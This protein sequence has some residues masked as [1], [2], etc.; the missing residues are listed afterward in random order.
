[1]TDAPVTEQERSVRLVEGELTPPSANQGL[2][3]VFRRRYL[4]RL[5]VRR[6]LRARYEASFLG[7]LWSYINPLSQFFIYWFVMGKI[8]G[9]HDNIPNYPVHVFS[10][11]IVVHFFTETFGA[12]TRSI[13]GNKAL[14]NKMAMPREMFPVAAM[15]VSL[16]HVLPQLVILLGVCALVGWH[17]DPT[18]FAALVLALAIVMILGTAL[19]LMFSVANVYF[20]DF[21]SFVGIL[22]NYVRF[23]V[24]M[25]Y[26]F[27]M[28]HDHL[29]RWAQEVWLADPIADAV[30][31]IQRAFWVSSI[32]G[33]HRH[34][35]MM[36]DHLLQRGVIMLG[37]SL[38]IL[39]LGQLVFAK[40]EKK[41]PERL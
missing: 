23:G 13:V 31:L 39:L 25:I 33:R 36:P 22:T 19:A 30:L 35:T 32:E 34:V 15:L 12:G 9:A 8:M 5:L 18:S 1:M 6:E 29:P 11:L 26:S 16:Y 4:L 41:I 24:P 28:I 14:V 20:R 3:E 27:D 38:L 2:L 21:G 10:A 37:V 40:F 7:F 17:P